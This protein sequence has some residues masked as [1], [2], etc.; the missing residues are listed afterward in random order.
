[1]RK[2]KFVT[3][4]REGVGKHIPQSK[5]ISVTPTPK[6]IFGPGNRVLRATMIIQKKNHKY[7]K[8]RDLY[9]GYLR[10]AVR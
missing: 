7:R 5:I 1:M 9:A 6:E 8:R 10:I 3:D 2:E 4:N